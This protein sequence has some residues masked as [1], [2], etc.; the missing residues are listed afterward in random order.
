MAVKRLTLK[1]E[2]DAFVLAIS[3][4]QKSTKLAWEINRVL[5]CELQATVEYEGN[6]YFVTSVE[7]FPYYKW[8][9]PDGRFT[10]H[11]IGNRSERAMLVPSQKMI[12]YFFVVTGFFEELDFEQGVKNI[13]KIESVLTAFPVVLD[14]IKQ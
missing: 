12:D 10:I 14:K 13:K 3:C 8:T 5:D 4:H 2:S 11:L 6:I 1:N 9:N 7:D